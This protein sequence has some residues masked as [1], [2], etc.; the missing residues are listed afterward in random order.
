MLWEADHWPWQ[1]EGGSQ[2]QGYITAV[3]AGLCIH[4]NIQLGW[5]LAWSKIWGSWFFFLFL[6]DD[7]KCKTSLHWLLL[8][9]Q[10][11]SLSLPYYPHTFCNHVHKQMLSLFLCAFNWCVSSSLCCPVYTSC[12]RMWS[13]SGC[14]RLRCYTTDW[15]TVTVT[16]C[17]SDTTPGVSS[18]NSIT[19]RRWRRTPSITT[20]TVSFHCLRTA[21][22]FFFFLFLSCQHSVSQCREAGLVVPCQRTWRVSQQTEPP[23][24]MDTCLTTCSWNLYM[25]IR[26]SSM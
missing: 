7:R 23:G 1:P 5:C 18:V 13:W 2:P 12:R 8:Y 16:L 19:C 14:G 4:T 15:S 20:S 11:N 3:D 25:I 24:H 22:Y 26:G 21:L 17:S 6:F 9:I 10:C